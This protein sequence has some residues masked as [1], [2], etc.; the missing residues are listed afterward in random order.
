MRD[1]GVGVH[2]LN[3][4]RETASEFP[5]VD[6][7]DAGSA[8][9]KVVHAL[10]GRECALLIDC[11]R[12]GEP[13]G[14]MKRFRPHEVVSRK[15]LVGISIHEGD[16]LAVLKMSQQLGELPK[17]TVVFA[18]EPAEIAPG[19]ALSSVLAERIEEYA[20]AIVNEMELLRTQQS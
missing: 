8:P 14:T 4:V 17:T 11:A 15:K 19:E 10:A 5:D 12:M 18:V 16:L 3:R 1:D 20:T 13:P 2:I 7:V 9:M 6:L